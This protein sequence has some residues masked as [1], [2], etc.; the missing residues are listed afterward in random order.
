MVSRDVR[1]RVAFNLKPNITFLH[2]SCY[3][4]PITLS[5][6]A[7][8]TRRHR[9]FRNESSTSQ[10]LS[11]QQLLIHGANCLGEALKTASELC[12]ELQ[13]AKT[14]AI[15]GFSG[16]LGLTEVWATLDS[17]A[18][19]GLISSEQA[20]DLN[21]TVLKSPRTYSLS[22][23]SGLVNASEIAS[24]QFP[25]LSHPIAPLILDQSPVC[26]SVGELVQ[27]F[28]YSEKWDSGGY[29]LKG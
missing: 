19:L 27:D 12:D 20:S 22:T 9:A 11:D 29:E 28:G 15:A 1:L 6:P 16:D 14:S 21:A 13:P 23:S 26:L 4:V 24:L 10:I 25:N 2:N 18:S 8:P 5:K 7:Y 17:G 3:P